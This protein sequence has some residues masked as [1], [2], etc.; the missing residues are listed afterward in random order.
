MKVELDWIF[1]IIDEEIDRV[2]RIDT[3]LGVGDMGGC[4]IIPLRNIK[5][6]IREELNKGDGE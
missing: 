2:S 4:M 6:T 1:E 3:N 5:R